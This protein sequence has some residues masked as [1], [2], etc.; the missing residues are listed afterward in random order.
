MTSPKPEAPELDRVLSNQALRLG[1]RPFLRLSDGQWSWVEVDDRVARIATGLLDR[2]VGPGRVVM[3]AGGRTSTQLFAWFAAQR[4][5]AVWAPLNPLL[6]GRPLTSVVATAAPDI[7][8]TDPTSLREIASLGLETVDVDDLAAAGRESW[9]PQRLPAS[10]RAKL[11]FTSGTTGEPKGVVWS[12]RCEVVWAHAYATELLDVDEG[13]GL[14]TCLPVSHVTGQGTVM[15]ALLRGAV[16]TLGES[17]SPFRFWDEVGAA[18]ARRFTFVGTILSTLLKRRPSGAERDH[19]LDRIIGAGAPIQRWA[20]IEERFGVA[21]VE[22]WGQTESAG[23]YTRPTSLPQRPGSIGRPGDR[24]E[25]H[26]DDPDR[27]SELLLRPTDR[28]AIFDGYLR[29][30]GSIESPYDGHGW[31]HTG[32]VMRRGADGDLEFIVR[33]RESIRRRGEI[34]ASVPIEEAAMEHPALTDAAAVAV[35]TDDGVDEEIK[36]CFTTAG[37]AVDPAELHRFLRDR[38]P[39]HMVPRYLEAVSEMPKTPS[40]RVQKFKLR[41]T[42]DGAWDARKR[43]PHPSR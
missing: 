16:L 11:M 1:R 34:I 25:V 19:Q 15:S 32:D 42:V 38:L 30:D 33:N 21:I 36:L 40:T 13:D 6:S 31:Y 2:G 12:R 35:A 26:L 41:A 28:G 39:S 37:P 14:Y 24:F 27:G 3:T 10:G 17:F 9:S 43:R 29:S 4:I 7:V 8:V 22:T 5:G 18:R 23:C 20:E